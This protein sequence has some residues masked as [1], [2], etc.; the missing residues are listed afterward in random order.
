MISK[1]EKIKKD[2]PNYSDLEEINNLF[3][4][5]K[6]EIAENKAKELIKK[7]PN[8]FNLNFMIGALCGTK[9]KLGEA[10][11]YFYK[12]IENKPDHFDTLFRL[13][14]TL[15]ILDR[16]EEGSK[17]LQKAI[18]IE[19]NNA[20]VHN[21]MGDNLKKKGNFEK[22]LFHY[23]KAIEINPNFFEAYNNSANIMADQN[24]FEESINYY[25]Q[26]LKIKPDYA[27]AYNNLGTAFNSLGKFEEAKINFQKALNINPNLTEAHRH[28]SIVTKYN[29]KNNIHIKKMEKL[30]SEKN[31]DDKKRVYLSFAL[32]KAF[33]DIKN[34]Q[35]AFYYF[36]EGNSLKRKEF[37]FSIESKNEFF[38]NTKNVF[39][40]KLFD[41]FEGYGSEDKTP[42]FI[43]GMPRSG[44]TLI[45]QIIS[46]HPDVYGAGEIRHFDML[47]RKNFL[48]QNKFGHENDL[49][50]YN[51]TKFKE[52]GESYI[53][54]IRKI[55]KTTNYISDK[56]LLNFRWI[57]L[58]KLALPN[59]KIIH[60]V[61]NSKDTCLSIFKNLFKGHIDFGY[62]LEEIGH[63]YNIYDNLMKHWKKVLPN[64]IYDISYEKLIENQEGETRKLLKKCNLIWNDQCIQFHKN[65]RPVVTASLFQIRSPI[66]KKS[67]KLWTRYEKQ[68]LPLTKI[69]NK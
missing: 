30:F 28:L 55:S 23:K 29:E 2:E 65:K 39:T 62:N 43:V 24:K 21:A 47:S 20:E 42:I 66:Y 10:V 33:E 60:C 16:L 44:S 51:P 18:L 31:I 3:K 14:I 57:G 45:E 5:Q 41:K 25:N 22:S 63:Y 8:S 1:N 61:R 53:N 67:V 58:I 13:G 64:Y 59:A 19:P 27:E 17:Y 12:A 69:L 37:N 4:S 7:Y 49:I 36:V 35:K 40:K 38:T 46:S 48:F 54:S 15:N 9:K 68:L 32:G 52:L 56:M 6:I 11:T 26:A 34:Y 50:N